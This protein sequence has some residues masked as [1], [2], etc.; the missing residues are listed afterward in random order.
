MSGAAGRITAKNPIV[1]MDG[2]EMTRVIWAM[3]KD[4]LI[5]PFVDVKLEYYDLGLPERDRTD[6]QVT[7][8]AADAIAKWGVGVKCATITPNEERVQEYKLKK[9]WPSPNGTIRAKLDGTVF[10][11]PILVH[12]VP[13]MVRSWVKPIVIGRHAYGDMYKSAEMRIRQPGKVELVFIPAD[14]SAPQRALI[15]DFTQP[16][17]VRGVHNLDPSIRSFAKACIAYALSEKMDL[18]FSGKDT[19]AKIYH[20]AFR[21]IFRQETEA[22]KADLEA[23]GITYT[24]LLIDDAVARAVRSPGGF[25][26]AC[27]NYDGDVMSDMVASGFGS[28]GLMTSVLVSPAGKFEYEAAHGTVTKHYRQHQKGEPTSTNSTATIFAWTGALAKRGELDETPELIRLAKLIE[29][30]VIETIESGTMTKDLASIAD[31]RPA[32]FASTRGFLEAIADK[33]HAKIENGAVA[34]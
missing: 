7:V 32:G 33:L 13:P 34:R 29:R 27:M 15:H 20:G 16:G 19:I 9:A 24:Y 21:E 26:W 5:T 28:L 2:D 14:G 31:P 11:K 4:L 3:V 1:E 18:W 12:N 23:A 8:D 6:D 10:R 25:L 30:S 22:R 17:I